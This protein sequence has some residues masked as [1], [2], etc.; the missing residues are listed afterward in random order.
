MRIVPCVVLT[1]CMCL[2]LA[3][4]EL[5]NRRPAGDKFA[6]GQNSGGNNAA[7]PAKKSDPGDPITGMGGGGSA[8]GFLAGQLIN[9]QT[10]R[11]VDGYIRWECLD[12][13]KDTGKPVEME[14]KADGNFAIQG[15]KSGKHYQLSARTRQGERMLAGVTYT[16]APNIRVV[17]KVREDLATA[18]T[19]EI[20]PPPA[21][22][23]KKAVPKKEES[24]NNK[25]TGFGTEQ[26]SVKV[27]G[28]EPGLPRVLVT[29]PN[30]NNSNTGFVPPPPPQPTWEAPST[31][32]VTVDP[33]RIAVTPPPAKV[34]ITIPNKQPPSTQ[35]QKPVPIPDNPIRSGEAPSLQSALNTP[36]VPSC[37]LYSS[38]VVNFALFDLNGAPWSY[39]DRKRKLVLLDFWGTNCMHCLKGTPE[40]IALQN[41]YGPAGL[42]VIGVACEH[43]G[44][45]SEQAQRV[46]ATA[47]RLGINY[48][49]LL[50]GGPQCPLMRNFNVSLLPTLVL[51]DENG[52]IVSRSEGLSDAS[53]I[54][55]LERSIRIRLNMN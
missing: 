14:V 3:G 22:A 42:E 4:C 43:G 6:P 5:F 41:R 15:L 25:D 24:S 19:P 49:L 2:S 36:R 44:S 46:V 50:G 26:A 13:P 10:G 31:N 47:K 27:Q 34:L 1:A 8:T 7:E 17:I 30:G 9:G 52:W 33:G 37:V 55:S 45:Q 28:W 35:L 48:Q 39:K 53:K 16:Q 51:I 40:L 12:E 29:I 23:P 54:Q 18:T 32:K 38:Q 20:P 11:P 21:Y